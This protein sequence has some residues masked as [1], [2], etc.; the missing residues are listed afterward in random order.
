MCVY[1]H[2]VRSIKAFRIYEISEPWSKHVCRNA[3]IIYKLWQ[4]LLS[5]TFFPSSSFIHRVA[6]ISSFFRPL[7][8]DQM[9][10]HASVSACVFVGWRRKSIDTYFKM[11]QFEHIIRC[12]WIVMWRHLLE[13]LNYEPFFDYASFCYGARRRNGIHCSSWAR[14]I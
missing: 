13:K 4:M 7:M 9:N 3:P 12:Y 1:M 6:Q 8:P 2:W 14:L 5:S 11:S 10:V